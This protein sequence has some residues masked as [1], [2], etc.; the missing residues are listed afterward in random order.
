LSFSIYNNLC[1]NIYY[2]EKQ[3]FFFT[4]QFFSNK[5]LLSCLWLVKCKCFWNN[6]KNRNY[7]SIYVLLHKNVVYCSSIHSLRFIKKKCLLINVRRKKNQKF[8]LIPR[9]TNILIYQSHVHTQTPSYYIK[10]NG[11]KKKKQTSL[12]KWMT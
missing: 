1:E 5:V 11:R 7:I 10:M 2:W 8:K 3:H 6:K 9:C 12:L 4:N